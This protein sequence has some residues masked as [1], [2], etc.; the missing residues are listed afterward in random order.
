MVL[1]PYIRIGGTAGIVGRG[2]SVT[3]SSIAAAG[4]ARQAFD[5]QADG[6]DLLVFIES[7]SGAGTATIYLSW[8]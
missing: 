1:R 2:E 5:V 3:V 4:T 6:D 7:I 8:R